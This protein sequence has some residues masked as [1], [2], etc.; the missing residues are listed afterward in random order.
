[1]AITAFCIM[2]MHVKELMGSQ[3]S[4]LLIAKTKLM[5]QHTDKY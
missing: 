1:M 5:R 4:L 2:L 3:F